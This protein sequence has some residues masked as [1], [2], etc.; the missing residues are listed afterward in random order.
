MDLSFGTRIRELR[1]IAGISQRKMAAL[2]GVSPQAA[3]KWEKDASCPDI[4]SLPR[5]AT[6][7]NITLDELFAPE[8]EQIDRQQDGYGSKAVW[9]KAAR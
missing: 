9:W 7:L 1:I 6:I 3:C 8:F 4:M 5:L 2:M